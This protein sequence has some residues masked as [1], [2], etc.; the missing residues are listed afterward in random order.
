[1][2]VVDG[3]ATRKTRG[4]FFTPA[5]LCRYVANWA[6]RA[7]DDTVL[8]PSCGEAAFL[9]AAGKRLDTLARATGG[10]LGCLDGIELHESSAREAERLVVAAGHDVQVQVGDFFL[11]TPT[12]TYDAVVG[13]PPYIR[14]QDF[15]GAVAPTGPGRPGILTLPGT[16]SPRCRL[17]LS[18]SAARSTRAP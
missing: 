14:Y 17:C 16:S 7:S 15:S 6:V 5:P 13:N 9:L 11:V 1:M 3:A 12:G 10:S 4:A 18:G 2:E 8:E